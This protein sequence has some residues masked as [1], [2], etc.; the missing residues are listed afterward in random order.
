M[1]TVLSQAH[2]YL[3]TS[4][5]GKVSEF[6][7]PDEEVVTTEYKPTDTIGIPYHYKLIFENEKYTKTDINKILM[8]TQNVKRLS[9]KMDGYEAVI[10]SKTPLNIACREKIDIIIKCLPK[11][12]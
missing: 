4:Y 1:A 11:G 6:K 2:L 5:F 7:F 3:G 10:S 8:E 12:E 9:A